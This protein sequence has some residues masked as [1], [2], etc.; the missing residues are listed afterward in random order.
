MANDAL[1]YQLRSQAEILDED[2]ILIEK[3]K[4]N[5]AAAGKLYDKYYSEILGYIYHCTLDGSVTED[6]TSNVFLAAFK[7]LGRFKWKQIPFR[8]WLYQI[9]TNEIRMHWRRQ[10]R[11]ATTEKS[12]H[13]LLSN[14]PAGG[15]N[16]AAQEEYHLLHKSLS[17]LKLK[18]RTVITLRYF[19]DKTI[20]E[21]CDI[22]G[23]KEGT[24]KSQLHRGLA[25][26][27]DIL[28]RMGV[29]PE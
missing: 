26:L 15:E 11:I 25:L 23:K 27:Q 1:E 21:I 20:S 29:L 16:I 10:K 6:L 4:K 14:E 24:I 28:I 2:K 5:P 7:H 13:E 18:Y 9:A 12:T 19:E 22:T 17:E 8:A 3:A